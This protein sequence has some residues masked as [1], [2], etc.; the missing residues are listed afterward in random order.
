SPAADSEMYSD[1]AA[2][3]VAD[4]DVAGLVVKVHVGS[5]IIGNVI[6]E[7]AD[8]QPGA[9]RLSEVRLGVSSGS[10]NVAPRNSQVRIAAD[11]SFRATGLPRGIAGFTMYYPAPKGLALVRVERDG[12]EQKNGIEV[13]SGEEISGVKVVFAYGTGSIR[14]Q[15]KVEGGDI[16]AA[17][18][19]FLNIRRAGTN[20]PLNMR[21]PTPDS[22]GRFLIDGL[23]PGE[24]E[25]SL[26]F[27]TRR[28][29]P[30]AGGP[31][32]IS[33]D[34]KQTVTVTNGKES[35][36]TMLVDLN[37]NDR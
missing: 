37:P 6:I 27:Q 1:R 3:T 19:M 29:P 17:A 33:K 32:I 23:L 26:L 30:V 36:V 13:G 5:S 16:P 21:N 25:L 34:V 12:V 20:Q 2:F 8:G 9:P 14:G 35:Q 10:L 15:V 4:S 11:G 22:R 18:M 31:P 28:A 24:Y 7:G